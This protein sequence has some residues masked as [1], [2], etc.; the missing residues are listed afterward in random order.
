MSPNY[1]PNRS[2]KAKI[3]R[4][5][6]QWRTADPLGLKPEKPIISFTFDD[7]P[8]SAA[9]EGAEILELVGGKGTYYASSALAGKQTAT[10][11]QF[12]AA[13]I[14]ALLK[15]GHEIGAHTHSHMD[16]SK[17]KIADIRSDIELNI[18]HLEAMGVSDVRQFAYPYGETRTAL[19][20]ELSNWFE[21]ARGVLPGLNT[22]TSDRLQLRA[23]E[24]TPDAKT[25]RRAA[26][27]IRAAQHNPTWIVIFTHDVAHS[28][29]PFGTYPQDL[30]LLTEMAHNIDADILC[31]GDA[32]KKMQ[33]LRAANDA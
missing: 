25:I 23:F 9:N 20:Q 22:E 26:A 28:P 17:E 29:S 4:R 27:A 30:K 7:F 33:T 5:I 6:T 21:T 19:K 2:V 31:V 15:G 24:L 14:E 10:G 12:G 13:D 3:S 1:A 18:R 16:C 8:K 11:E 32:M